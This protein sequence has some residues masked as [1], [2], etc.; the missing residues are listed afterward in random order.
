MVAF[1]YTPQLRLCP[2][3]VPGHERALR[4]IVGISERKL[5]AEAGCFE[6]LQKSNA[7]LR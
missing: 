1:L 2:E 4:G 6:L 7:D 5:G 3:A